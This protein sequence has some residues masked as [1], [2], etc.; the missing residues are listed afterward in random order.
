MQ[1]AKA[2]YGL[3]QAPRAWF[4]RLVATLKKFGFCSSRCDNSLFICNTR[5]HKTFVLFYVDDILVTGS[6]P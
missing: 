2:L 5:D 4:E 3:K 1:I 6:S